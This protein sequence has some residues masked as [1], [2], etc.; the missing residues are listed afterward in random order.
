[1]TEAFHPAEAR[2]LRQILSG[3]P[4]SEAEELMRQRVQGELV[5]VGVRTPALAALRAGFAEA[6][7]TAYLG[8]AVQ[9]EPSQPPIEPRDESAWFQRL[10]LK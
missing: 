1:M 6:D 5:V 4:G 9:V 8:G 3:A 7:L 10:K 2:K